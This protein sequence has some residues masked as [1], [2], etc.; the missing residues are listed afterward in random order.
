MKYMQPM[1]FGKQYVYLPQVN[2]CFGTH[3][4]KMI[5]YK[6]GRAYRCSICT[7]TLQLR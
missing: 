7:W 5:L 2:P 1:T 3:D 4:W 6:G